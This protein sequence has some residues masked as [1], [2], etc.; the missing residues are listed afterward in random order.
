MRVT[1]EVDASRLNAN[2]H[3]RSRVSMIN[4]DDLGGATIETFVP[5]HREAMMAQADRAVE[6][7]PKKKKYVDELDLIELPDYMKAKK[8]V[9]EEKAEIP[10]LPEVGIDKK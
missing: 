8:T 2:E 4:T 10:S 9:K 7:L 6:A 5:K 3:Y 1:N